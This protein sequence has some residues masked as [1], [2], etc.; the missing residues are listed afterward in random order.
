MKHSEWTAI[1]EK[2]K[3]AFG[4]N[5]DVENSPSS[6]AVEVILAHYPVPMVS[7]CVRSEAGHCRLLKA[8]DRT[9]K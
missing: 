1:L 3:K 8:R 9:Q 6:L 7:T 5:G 4:A 2:N